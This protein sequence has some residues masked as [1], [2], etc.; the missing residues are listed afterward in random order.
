MREPSG[1]LRLARSYNFVEK[2]SIV[3]EIRTAIQDSGED[4][5]DIAARANVHRMTLHYWLNGK[6]KNPYAPTIEKVARALGKRLTLVDGELHLGELAPPP[7]P[8]TRR[9]A[10]WSWRRYQ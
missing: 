4:P 3:D 10:V 7:P 5:A 6:I 8:R 1:P 2:H 9:H